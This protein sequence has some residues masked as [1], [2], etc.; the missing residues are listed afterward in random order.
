MTTDTENMLAVVSYSRVDEEVALRMVKKLRDAG[1]NVWIDQLNIFK[2]KPWDDSIQMAIRNA[3]DMIV[4]L[5]ATSV[6]SPNVKDEIAEAFDNKIRIIPVLISHCRMPLRLKR[7]QY[8][9]ATED[10]DLAVLDILEVLKSPEK[11][12]LLP[13]R[14]IG[15]KLKI[16]RIL[17]KIKKTLISKGFSISV[18]IFSLSGIYFTPYTTYSDHTVIPSLD[19]SSKQDVI[20]K[21]NQLKSSNGLL[22]QKETPITT[23]G[24]F[25]Y[26]I[27]K[28]DAIK[29]HEDA[30]VSGGVTFINNF[31]PNLYISL[32]VQ[33]MKEIN[34][35]DLSG[36]GIAL[37]TKIRSKALFF[38]ASEADASN[39]NIPIDIDFKNVNSIG[40]R[41]VDQNVSAFI[42]NKMVAQYTFKT[43][44]KNCFPSL[45]FKV[46][47]DKEGE[48]YFQGLT[49]YEFRNR[50]ILGILIPKIEF[51]LNWIKNKI[52]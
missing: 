38:W 31:D 11:S 14:K 39:G 6:A 15:I 46:N 19:E 52:S 50:N 30:K 16:S 10:Q 28:Y 4:L 45:Y 36:C 17:E 2:G 27:P 9:D 44:P 49:A 22:Q 34:T 29:S 51:D 48:V 41:Q 13:K 42:N 33:P 3:S 24:Y 5:S 47:T 23:N 26:L 21:G 35:I 1:A 43:K 32:Q 25:T 20:V 7:M 18:I 37:V 40:L 12:L 8:I